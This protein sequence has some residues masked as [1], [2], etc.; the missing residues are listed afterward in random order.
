ME[1]VKSSK[2][3]ADFMA[4]SIRSGGPEDYIFVS[5]WVFFDQTARRALT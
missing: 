2:P 3:S 4:L 1:W 5:F